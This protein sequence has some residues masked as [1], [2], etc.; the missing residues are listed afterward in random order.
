MPVVV[1]VLEPEPEESAALEVQ[2][3]EELVVLTV[4]QPGQMERQT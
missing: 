2:E 4:R 3:V 1:V